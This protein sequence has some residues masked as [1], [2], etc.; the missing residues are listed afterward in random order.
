MSHSLSNK[1]QNS[2]NGFNIYIKNTAQTNLL[3]GDRK[4]MHRG[5]IKLWR[6][7]TDWEWYDEP[8][9]LWFFV[10]IL[11]M[12]NWDDKKWHGITIKS[13]Q[14]VSSIEH[15][16]FEYKESGKKMK[17]STMQVRNVLNRLKATNEITSVSTNNY[18]LFSI[19]NWKKYQG[20]ETDELTSHITNGQQTDN[21]R[22]TTTKEYKNNKNIYS[23]YFYDFWKA[24]PKKQAFKRTEGVFRGLKVDEGLMG[25]ILSAISRQ[26]KT[27]QWSKDNGKWIPM[28]FKWLADERWKDEVTVEKDV[29]GAF[30]C[31]V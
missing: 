18:T 28:P 3:I 1:A 14:F 8:I 6:K 20:K 30:R 24:Y 26:K 10:K 21:K 29:Q 15:L 4:L 23:K 17:L 16:R 11:F 25:V 13:G 5:Y 22:I 2:I 31:V 7:I 27:E 9:M 19:V 12:A